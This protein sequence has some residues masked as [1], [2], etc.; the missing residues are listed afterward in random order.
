MESIAMIVRA[1]VAGAGAVSEE[2]ASDALKNAYYELKT[3]VMLNWEIGMAGEKADTQEVKL[4]LDNLEDDPEMFQ[5]A[6]EKRLAE[7]MP[8]PAEELVAKA[9]QLCD[10]LDETGLKREGQSY[11]TGDLNNVADKWNQMGKAWADRGN[12]TKAI[13]YYEQALKVTVLAFGDDHPNVAKALTQLGSIWADKGEIDI[14]SNYFQN[15]LTM[16]QKLL[17][18]Q[19]PLTI[20]V[21]NNLK[22]VK[23]PSKKQ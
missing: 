9:Q 17:G 16:S 15:A 18:T 19:H 6:V 14:A 13:E 7:A 22:M 3:D 2:T 11:A 20:Q 23:G 4:L 10:Q 5:I 1:L 12:Y 8:T 21:S